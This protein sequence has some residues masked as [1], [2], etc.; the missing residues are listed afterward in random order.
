MKSSW[1]LALLVLVSG[2][3]SSRSLGQVFNK[4]YDPHGQQ[5]GQAAFDIEK[6]QQEGYVVFINSA[7]YDSLYY[8]SVA[9]A[10]RIDANGETLS[11]D[12][13]VYPLHGTYVGWANNAI[14]LGAKGFAIGGSV[15][16]QDTTKKTALYFVDSAGTFETL[17]E[18]GAQHEE[19][20]GRQ[21]K[22]TADGGFIMC[23]ETT[24]V[25]IIDG[26]LLKTDS[27]GV[28]EWVQTYGLPNKR[29]YALTVELG[30]SG[31]YY[32]GGFREITS[33]NYDQWVVRTD[34]LGSVIWSNDYGTPFNDQANA[35]LN[36]C[37]DGNLLFASSWASG[38]LSYHT[39]CLVKLDT[40][41]SVIWSHT[42]G[43]DRPNHILFAV[44]ECA[45]NDLIAVG[46]TY[47]F[48]GIQGVLLR[49]NSLGDSLWMRYYYY[50]DS[51]MPDGEGELKDVIQTDDGGFIAVGTAYGSFSGITP[52]G[53]SQDVWVIK[54]DSLGCIVPG[55]QLITGIVSH[56]TNLKEA[57]QV[58]PNPAADHVQVVIDLP[59]SFT[60]TG[61]LRYTLTD[62]SGR[63]VQQRSL[64][65]HEL[66]F[67]LDVHGLP[68][69]LFHL[70]LSDDRT[71]I[72]GTKLVVER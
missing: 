60:P 21:V 63:I 69:G 52:P 18:Y 13:I 12:R 50:Q 25:G 35:H 30:P 55:C 7:Y 16:Y 8:N 70:H 26:F 20:L 42:Y 14:A 36:A 6:A 11:V 37:S 56:I 58:Q 54:T 53:L 65:A 67:D 45:N 61:A 29:D 3:L 19:W 46:Q 47:W 24:T 27:L 71:W 2:S 57:L 41:G 4:R 40:N 43:N 51:V 59:G 48:D 28:Q 49:T 68:P 10:M 17:L 66:T 1:Q 31:G 23:G 33:S 44:K 38:F 9:T 32:F 15:N 64:A 5:L 72:S 22:Q 34:A 39:D 62:G